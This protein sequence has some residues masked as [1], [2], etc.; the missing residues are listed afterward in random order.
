MPQPA[1]NFA[2]FGLQNSSFAKP[3]SPVSDSQQPFVANFGDDEFD[4]T[5]VDILSVLASPESDSDSQSTNP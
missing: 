4:S 1:T 2:D 3:T 5:S